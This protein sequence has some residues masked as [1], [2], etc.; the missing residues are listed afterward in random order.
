[1]FARVIA[2]GVCLAVALGGC[3]LTPTSSSTAGSYTG[4]SAR[5]ATAL[6]LFA[7]DASSENGKDICANVLASSVRARL[8]KIGSCATIIQD[9]LKTTDDSTLTIEAIKVKGSNASAQVQTIHDRNKVI[10]TVTLVKQ[11]GGWR[12]SGI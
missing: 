9:Q 5:I 3:S 11:S 2:G 1:V 12:I 8:N 4:P 10:S 6:N 7:S